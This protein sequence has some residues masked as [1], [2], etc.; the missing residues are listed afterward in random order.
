MKLPIFCDESIYLRYAQL[1]RRAPL[2]NALVSLVDPKPPLHYWLLAAVF[3]WTADPLS[4]GRLLSVAAGLV[5]V[6]LVLPLCDEIER[7]GRCGAEAA[8]GDQPRP[9]AFRASAAVLF[10]TCPFLAFYQRMALAEALLVAETILVAWL[11]LRLARD[12]SRGAL[13]LLDPGGRG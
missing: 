9:S 4:A 13:A 5:T 10:L 6:L 2:G 3:G 12:P 11:S 7:L 1:I 8:R